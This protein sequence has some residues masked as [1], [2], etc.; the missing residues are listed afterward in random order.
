MV[1]AF[2]FPPCLIL[3]RIDW[4]LLLVAFEELDWLLAY[5]PDEWR[6]VV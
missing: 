3:S 4:E 6:L 1:V 5:E 2:V